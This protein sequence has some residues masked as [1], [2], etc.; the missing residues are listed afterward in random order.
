MSPIDLV[1]D[2]FVYAG[3]LRSSANRHR[4]IHARGNWNQHDELAGA[5][6][7]LSGAGCEFADQSE[8]FVEGLAARIY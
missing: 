2:V 6:G 7:K 8:L 4:A 1:D 3:S 5:I